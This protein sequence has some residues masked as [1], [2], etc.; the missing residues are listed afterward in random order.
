[1]T[2]AVRS[3]LEGAGAQPPPLRVELVDA[4]ERDPERMSKLKLVRSEV[5]RPS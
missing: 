1:M 5:R 2:A 3:Q 4:I